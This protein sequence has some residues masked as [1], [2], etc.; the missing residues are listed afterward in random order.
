[1]N[2]DNNKPGPPSAGS[3]DFSHN[4]NCAQSTATFPLE[5]LLVGSLRSMSLACFSLP[6]LEDQAGT[7]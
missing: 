4:L 7:L 5:R 2:A 3:V 1:M 6:D